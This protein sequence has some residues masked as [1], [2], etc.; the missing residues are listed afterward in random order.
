MECYVMATVLE[1]RI[2]KNSNV[3]CCKVY[4]NTRTWLTRSGPLFQLLSGKLRAKDIRNEMTCAIFFQLVVHT[5]FECWMTFVWVVHLLCVSVRTFSFTV[6]S[7]SI[8]W[9]ILPSICFTLVKKMNRNIPSYPLYLVDLM[10]NENCAFH[11]I[12]FLSENV[13]Q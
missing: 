9:G 13:A 5:S 11:T 3:S 12:A 6:L 1:N 10:S 2:S 7:R 4:L 8:R